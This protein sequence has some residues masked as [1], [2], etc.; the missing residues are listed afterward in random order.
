MSLEIGNLKV[1]KKV[2]VSPDR[3]DLILDIPS[4]Y[5]LETLDSIKCATA[6]EKALS[7][8]EDRKK[9]PLNVYVQVNTSGEE[10][11]GGLDPLT[12][13]LATSNDDVPSSELVSLAKHVI[14]SCPSLHLQGV[15]TIG[16]ASNSKASS[17]N[18]LS[19]GQP[20]EE[21]AKEACKLNP[22]FARLTET[23]RNLVKVLRNDSEVQ[24]CSERYSE[25]LQGSQ[26][27]GGLELSMGM[28][29]DL[30]VAIRAGSDNVRVGTDCF[31][32]RPPSRDEAMEGMKDELAS[33]QT[34]Q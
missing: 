5:L 27:T 33:S 26:D 20:A 7:G 6:L 32:I 34:S 22:D 25:L 3:L 2:D 18:L 11:K 14:T 9:Q 19:D 10:A 15:M 4:L 31:G 16:A 17:D 13:D 30:E 12:D 28:S 24:K 23:R 29:N 1:G 8:Q 21:I